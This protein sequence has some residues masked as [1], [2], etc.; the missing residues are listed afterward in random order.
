MPDEKARSAILSLHVKNMNT[1]RINVQRVVELTEG[2]SGAELKATCVEAGMNAIRD[3]RDTV[4]QKDILAAVKRI[5]SKRN[6]G[7][8][9][10]T[11]E[12]LYS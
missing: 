3:K 8:I 10:A 6:Q 12:G 5:N 4:T 2:Y 1:K 9:S 11:P 7:G